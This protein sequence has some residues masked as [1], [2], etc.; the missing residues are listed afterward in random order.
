[1]KH[2]YSW[3]LALALFILAALGLILWLCTDSYS[4]FGLNFLS[5]I[6]GASITIFIIDFLQDKREEERIIPIKAIAFQ[7]ISL[8]FNRA[9]D[10]F[11]IMYSESVEV[12]S[13]ASIIEF[14]E[15][16]SMMRAL[17]CCDVTKPTRTFPVLT[18]EHYLKN[19]IEQ[20]RDLA[21][22]VLNKGTIHVEPEALMAIHY[23]FNESPFVI[24]LGRI[25]SHR[26]A[27]SSMHGN[28]YSN[29]VSPILNIIPPNKKAIESL[30]NLHNWLVSEKQYLAKRVSD[31]RSISTPADSIEPRH[32]SLLI[33]RAEDSVIEKGI[34][35]VLGED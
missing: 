1:M 16:D 22:K 20:L 10:I 5:E 31:L 9:M 29:N 14:L 18:L 7:D 4:E 24:S 33:L 3:T 35:R 28:I 8:L 32:Q 12:D 15:G 30:I 26:H 25:D 19:E 23:L 21:N 34:K 6:V 17:V 2:I 27:I 13:P 11:Y